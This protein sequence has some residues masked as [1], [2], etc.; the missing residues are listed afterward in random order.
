LG[1]E[2]FFVISGF[3]IPY[4]LCL[5]SYRLSDSVDFFVRRLKRLEPPYLACIVFVVALQF[6]SSITPGFL[7]KP[8]AIGLPQLLA[9]FAYLNAILEYGWLNPVFWTLAIEFQ[10]YIFMAFAF[11]LLNHSNPKI[12]AAAIVCTAS[13]GMLGLGK[14]S[15][16]I[17][18]LPLFAIGVA[19]CQ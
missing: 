19:S 15:L 6:L 10:F 14:S 18:W 1:V 13:L 8:F 7:G 12:S 4:S 3:V 5:R 11:P 2:A 16:L 9:H 17:H